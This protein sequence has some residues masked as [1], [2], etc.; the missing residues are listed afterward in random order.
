MT[1]SKP[2]YLPEDSSPSTITL[3]IRVSTFGFGET[4]IQLLT[5]GN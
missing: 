1:S 3:E 2:D 4:G 5:A